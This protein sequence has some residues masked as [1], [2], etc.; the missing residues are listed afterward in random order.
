M[1]GIFIENGDILKK[2]NADDIYYFTRDNSKTYAV[3][4]DG[5][6]EV[7]ASLNYISVILEKN[8]IRTHKS[9]IVNINKINLIKKSTGNTYNELLWAQTQSQLLQKR[10]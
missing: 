10:V 9:F 7:K 6:F 8:F 3:I 5:R 1:E 2:I 4:K